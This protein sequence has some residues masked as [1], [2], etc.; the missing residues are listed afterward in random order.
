MSPAPGRLP[1]L[2][3]AI[4][5]DEVTYSRPD[6]SPLTPGYLSYADISPLSAAAG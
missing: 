6:G 1:A 2:F 3:K 4:E 5:H